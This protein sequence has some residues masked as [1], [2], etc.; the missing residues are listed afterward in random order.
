MTKRFL[1]VFLAVITF[2]IGVGISSL[3]RAM[4]SRNS[5]SLLT[6]RT[7]H[8]AT[9][10]KSAVKR[11]Y[12]SELHASGRAGRYRACFGVFSSSD[13]MKFSSTN[14]Y[15]DS[16]KQAQR[17]LRNRLKS[18][19]EIVSRE[20]S[21]DETGRVVGEAV[22][23]TFPP[24]ERVPGASAQLIVIKGS[25]FVSISSSSLRNIIEY[26]KDLKP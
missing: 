16:P 26:K 12:E 10:I 15:F 2:G 6:V 25:D 13:G 24:Y 8:F 1:S 17:E 22:V 7:Q 21:V 4:I 3:K 23:A 19:L 20:S 11:S 5:Q 18:S 9:P 14:I